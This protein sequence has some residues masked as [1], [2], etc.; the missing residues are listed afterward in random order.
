[1]ARRGVL[2]GVAGVTV[3][4]V[5]GALVT[6]ES[7]VDR[8]GSEPRADLDLVGGTVLA[9]NDLEPIREG[10]VLVRDGVIVDVGPSS[11]V[12][13]PSHVTT[14]D[15]AG[16]TVMPGLIDLHVHLGSPELDAREGSSLTDLPGMFLDAVR[17]AP[18]HRRA[19]LEHGVTTGT[20][21]R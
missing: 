20:E 4:L 3:V 16:R 1:M 8:S 13:V 10:T 5:G 7:T 15:V 12:E 2:L 6:Y 14:I 17:Y 11:A 18:G 9:G 19:A 21:R